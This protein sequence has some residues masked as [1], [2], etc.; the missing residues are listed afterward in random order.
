MDCKDHEW[1]IYICFIIQKG[2][3]KNNIDC[4]W[5][6]AY[7]KAFKLRAILQCEYIIKWTRI[8]V[9]YIICLDAKFH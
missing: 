5:G 4:E 2:K 7:Y 3:I 8:P 9:D 1:C 6:R